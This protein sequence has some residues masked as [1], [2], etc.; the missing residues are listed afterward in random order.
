MSFLLDPPALFVLGVLLYFVGNR[1]KMERLARITIGLLIVLSFILFSL[2]LYTDTFRCVFPI[3]CNNMSGS[4]FMFHSDITGIYKKDVPLLVVIFLFVLYPLWIYFGYAA[5]LMLSKRRRFSKEV[6]SYK[7]VKSHRNSAPLKYSV[8]RYPDNGRDINDPG[9][10]VRAAVEALGGMQNFVKRGDNVMVKVNI[11]GGVP[12]LVGTFTTKEV[13][14]YVVDMVREAGGEPFICDA[15]MVWTKFWSNAKDEGWIEWAAQKGVKLVNL[16]DTKIVYF[17]FGEDSL[18]QRERVSK[19]IVNADVII[20]IPA[21]KTH[22]MTSVTL[23]M[24]NM[25]G[26]FPEIDKAKYHKL[27]INEVIYWVNRAFTP[28]LT[29]IDGTIGGETVGPLSCEPV[30]FR[31]IVASNSVVTADAIAAQLMGYKN[32]VRE[33]DHLK[34]A[35]ERGLGD[36]SVKFDPSSLPPH[37]SDGKW[38]LPD[39]DVAKLYVKSTHMLLQIPG[40]DTFFNMGS[41]VFLFDAS[42]L[43]LIKYFT[44]GFL[45]ILNDVIKWTMDKKPDTPESKKRKGINLGIV[46]VLAILSVI[47]F[48]SE[49]FIAKSSLEFSL[50]FLAAIV[51]GAI[52]A[53][54]MKTKHLVSISLASILVSYAVERYA[55]LAGM[56]HYIDGSAPP[57]FALFSTPIFIITILGITS[58]LQRIFA[59]MNL[60]GKRLRIFPAA[61]IILAFAVFMVFEGYSALATPQ[62]IAMY[63]GFAVLSLFYN[64]RQG[65][66]W[67]FAFAIVAVAL[68]GSMELLGAVSGLWSYAFREGLPIFISL[69]WALNA[70][71]ACGITQVFGVNMRDAVVK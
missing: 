34:L 35:H 31:T 66:E 41:D 9:Q 13:A 47:G 37:I 2:L 15:D 21:M 71:A 52:F 32:P 3:I 36:A 16:S 62:V 51:L 60:K 4:E 17:N 44:P 8:V 64:N 29:I 49:G 70:W 6:Y 57:F 67:N 14:G 10:A 55:V 28:N 50:G 7:D 58:Y 18:L 56:W 40:W 22:M 26:T 24:K 20:S 43:P 61:L 54:R 39:P 5:V 38:N 25:Y 68:G 23:G 33:I 46:I 59:F 63:V 19:E 53:R 45:S 12:E 1:L 42:R 69:A 48:I 30:D 27:G 11:C 65:L